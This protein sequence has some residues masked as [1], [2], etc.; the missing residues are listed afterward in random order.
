MQKRK[1]HYELYLFQKVTSNQNENNW[2]STSIWKLIVFQLVL[3]TLF[4]NNGDP[5]TPWHSDCYLN[6]SMKLHL[7]PPTG[8]VVLMGN[9]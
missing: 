4:W 8:H 3:I 9:N 2:W 1:E 6:S 7:N 5:M